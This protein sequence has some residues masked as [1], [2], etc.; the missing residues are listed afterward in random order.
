MVAAPAIGSAILFPNGK[1][2]RGPGHLGF[3]HEQVFAQFN[4]KHAH[5]SPAVVDT[6][7]VW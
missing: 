4:A 6:S 7:S 1:V 3:N 5:F 2:R